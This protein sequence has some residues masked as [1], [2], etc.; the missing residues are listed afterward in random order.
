V[1][2]IYFLRETDRSNLTPKLRSSKSATNL[3][4]IDQQP[5]ERSYLRRPQTGA[6]IGSTE[7]DL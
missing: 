7:T 4:R 1:D 3:L 5:T 6:R 2:D